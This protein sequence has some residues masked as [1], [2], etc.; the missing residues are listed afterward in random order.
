M[1]SPAVETGTYTFPP[2]PVTPAREVEVTRRWCDRMS[3]DRIIEVVCAVCGC[4]V[5]KSQVVYAVA[6]TLELSVL[7]RPG[8]GVTRKERRT[9]TEPV[10][11]LEGPILNPAGVVELAGKRCLQ[12]CRGCSSVVGRG[13]MPHNALANGRWI[14]EVP[15]CL[16]VLLFGEQLLVRLCRPNACVAYVEGGQGYLKANAVI[17]EQPV[18]IVYDKLP[19]PRSDVSECFAVIFTGPVKPTDEEYKRTPFIVRLRFVL[20]ALEW[21]C[22]NHV[23]YQ[24]VQIDHDRLAEYDDNAIPVH[25]IYRKGPDEL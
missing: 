24:G 12:M 16:K 9:A 2:M 25:V 19:P 10:S 14:G 21:L 8:E 18:G 11:E 5:S 13:N 7:E 17:F 15:D 1:R 3:A 6:D 23:D 20:A 22:L 4:L